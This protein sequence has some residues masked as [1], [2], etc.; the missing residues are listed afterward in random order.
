MKTSNLILA[1]LA[2]FASSAF[3]TVTVGCEKWQAKPWPQSTDQ[4]HIINLEP[5][6]PRVLFVLT[7]DTVIKIGTDAPTSDIVVFDPAYTNTVM[8]VNGISGYN[9]GYQRP[10]S[11]NGV[12]VE[13][14]TADGRNWRAQW[15]EVK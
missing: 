4:K 8:T 6:D 3:L 7:N 12:V 11:T 2:V 9:G 5:F 10:K 14:W 15:V 13:L 1:G